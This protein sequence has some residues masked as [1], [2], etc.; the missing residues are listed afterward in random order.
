MWVAFSP[1][2]DA[3]GHTVKHSSS[4]HTP[5]VSYVTMTLRPAYP[6]LVRPAALLRH[7]VD[8]GPG[9]GNTVTCRLRASVRKRSSAGT[10]RRPAHPLTAWRTPRL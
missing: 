6:V 9:H 3:T 10:I 8:L 5:Y 7:L 4:P 1:R 2:P